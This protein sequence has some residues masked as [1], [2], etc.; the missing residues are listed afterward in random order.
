MQKGVRAEDLQG[1]GEG[2]GGIRESGGVRR[3][4]RR[5]Q[6]GWMEV[7][8]VEEEKVGLRTEM[9]RG[10]QLLMVRMLGREELPLL[11]LLV[12]G[13]QRGLLVRRE[14]LLPLLLVK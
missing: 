11:L 9:G 4:M 8:M 12:V 10:I 14:K 2:G 3:E 13:M 5:L 6:L 7:G 1:E